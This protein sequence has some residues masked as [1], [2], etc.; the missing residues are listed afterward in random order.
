M[1][2]YGHAHRKERKRL[3]PI[4]ARGETICWRCGELIPAH[5]VSRA[6]YVWDLGHDDDDPSVTRGPEHREC[7]RATL[8]HARDGATS[9]VIIR[10]W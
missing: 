4:V 6:R 2:D 8:T 1:P 5:D 10:G 3:E 7:N 9:A